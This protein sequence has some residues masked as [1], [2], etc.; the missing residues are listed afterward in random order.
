MKTTVRI[1]AIIFLLFLGVQLDAQ[2]L[3]RNSCINGISNLTEE[4]KASISELETSYQKQMADYRAERRAT[5]DWEVK[6]DIREEMLNVR[7]EHHKQINGLL[8]ADQ[9]KEF[10]AWIDARKTRRNNIDGNWGETGKQGKR[11]LGNGNGRSRG[12]CLYNN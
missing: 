3:K 5:N 1:L 2:N 10:A 6:K 8:N 4:Q 11:G 7:A 12:A 9:Q